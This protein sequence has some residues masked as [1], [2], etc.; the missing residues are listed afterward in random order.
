MR[1]YL[2]G[3]H[4]DPSRIFLPNQ[5]SMAESRYLAMLGKLIPVGCSVGEFC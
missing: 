1:A 5:N 3:L 4:F 2:N